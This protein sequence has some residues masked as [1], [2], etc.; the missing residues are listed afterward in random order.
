MLEQEL[1]SIMGYIAD[2]TQAPSPYYYNVPR[3]FCVP[4]VYYPVPEVTTGGE[5]L[6]T[7]S[8]DYVWY[9]KFFHKTTHEAY[10]L[11]MSVLTAMREERNLIPLLAEDGSRIEGGWLRIN[12]PKLKALDDG[13]AQLTI[14]WRSR[15]PYKDAGEGAQRSQA[16]YFDVFMKSGKEISDT[17]AEALEKYAVPFDSNIVEPENDKEVDYGS[18]QK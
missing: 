2:K 18:D 8:M 13:A 4:A 12:D 17:Y 11:G 15:R 1:A 9:I 3:H 6:S 7:Y 5:T 16:F 10:G 14:S